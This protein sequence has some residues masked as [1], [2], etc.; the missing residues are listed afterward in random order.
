MNGKLLALIILISFL[1]SSSPVL[2][3]VDEQSLTFKALNLLHRLQVLSDR[4][5]NVSVYIGM[6]NDA[7]N[8]IQDGR[9]GDA[10]I[11]LDE[12][13]VEVVELEGIA[14]QHYTWMKVLKYTRIALILLIPLLFYLLFPRIYIY[15]WF[16][17]RRGW[18]VHGSSG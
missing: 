2:G 17:F 7:L 8:L 15:L 18:I 11:L 12:I 13:E 16:R 1:P 9:L 6:L 3:G 14:D 10:E 5:F 4:G